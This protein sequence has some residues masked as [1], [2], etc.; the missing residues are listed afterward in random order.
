MSQA[1][2]EHLDKK[3]LSCFGTQLIE[4]VNNKQNHSKSLIQGKD[5]RAMTKYRRPDTS[6]CAAITGGVVDKVHRFGKV[7]MTT[8][9]TRSTFELP[10]ECIQSQSVDS[11]DLRGIASFGATCPWHSP[12]SASSGASAAELDLMDYCMT[13]LFLFVFPHHPNPSS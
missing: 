8:P 9:V 10:D 11:Y 1:F 6:D 12:T 3:A 13:K 7:L 4:D 2:K 5:K